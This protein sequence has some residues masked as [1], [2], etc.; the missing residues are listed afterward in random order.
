MKSKN[1][2]VL[3]EYNP[4]LFNLINIDSIEDDDTSYQVIETR[5]GIPTIQVNKEGRSRFV[6]SK[7]D[8]KSEAEKFI[9]Q[10]QENMGDY[11]HVLF[12][13]VGLGYHIEAFTKRNPMFKF[14][15]YEP[16]INI[17][18]LYAEHV[19]IPLYRIKNI[20][21]ET[22][23]EAGRNFLIKLTEEIQERI[24]LII[25]PSY[26]QIF[27]DEFADFMEDFK[28]AVE[29][30]KQS[31]YIDT[32]FSTR[33]TINSLLNFSTTIKT[34]NILN[35]T[36]KELFKQ[37]PLII[38]SA[39]PSLEEEYE[40][41]RYIKQHKLAY[42]FAVGSAN[43]ALI[44]QNIIPDA[45]TTYDPQGHNHN[46]YSSII[47]KGI[48]SIPM[49][50]G[51]SVG[52]ETL[53]LFQGPKLHMF[54]SQDT[55]S[56]YY[57]Q[58]Q[59][60]MNFEFIEDAPTIA[61]VTFQLA[62]KLGCSPVVFVGQNLAYRNNQYYSK[63]VQ[64]KDRGRSFQLQE[65]DRTKTTIVKDVY[66]M[67]IESSPSFINMLENME[68]YIA[69]YKNV[70]VINTTNGG[71][72]IA[73]T[74]F[75]PLKDFTKNRL[76][77][78]VVQENWFK[79][80][81]KEYSENHILKYINKMEQSMENFQKLYKEILVVLSD[82]QNKLVK[83]NGSQL[84]K[85]FQKFDKIMKKIIMNECYITYIYP[86][87]RSH[88]QSLSLK[89]ANIRKQSNDIEKAKVLIESFRPFLE[90]CNETIERI[91]ELILREHYQLY[92][93]INHKCYKYYDV[94]NGCFSFTGHVKKRY[95]NSG[96]YLF[97]QE[98]N[99]DYS[100]IKFR[101]TGKYLRLIGRKVTDNSCIQVLIDGEAVNSSTKN[102][103]EIKASVFEISNLENQE[104][105]VEIRLLE[106]SIFWFLGVEVE[107][108]ERVLHVNEVT[109]IDELEIGKKI[110]CH[111]TATYNR[112]GTFDNLGKET[113]DFIPN[114]SMGN[115]NGDFYFIMVDEDGANK[116]L[117]ADRN[118]Q[119]SVSFKRLKEG[120]DQNVH[121]DNL[122]NTRIRLPQVNRDIDEWILYIQN[123]NLNNTIV[124]NDENVWNHERNVDKSYGLHSFIDQEEGKSA[125]YS[126]YTNNEM[127]IFKENTLFEIDEK[128]IQRL[129]GFRPV[130]IIKKIK[131]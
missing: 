65:T 112:I 130:L 1:L 64:Y 37:K 101:F 26:Q 77:S 3:R 58:N 51:T 30:K 59:N 24:L 119:N 16:K 72:A 35:Q 116:K 34:P 41:L 108:N 62:A 36:Y 5:T 117:I 23:R 102:I 27:K 122:L 75:I 53:N 92:K 11:D 73:G 19:D 128:D 103:S 25:L 8:P 48:E 123:S 109:T 105:Q 96:I 93:N 71:A 29:Y 120:L 74:E 38:V 86:I 55:V 124:A 114:E 44:A 14:S 110:R 126:Y 66:G 115:P 127:N 22:S 129:W 20:F 15:I 107:E 82:I 33:W 94:N 106:K 70:E 131:V 95:R 113:V 88:F 54:T 118:I 60:G 81:Q 18:K 2:S 40:N 89:A 63:E 7:Y 52:F 49:I 47:E 98:T 83:K 69:K 80:T 9:E 45:V 17:F 39:G 56:K 6:H 32:K 57:L 79:N 12:Y 10:F 84:A 13:G 104:H 21:V 61:S 90:R 87:N 91:T 28:M 111:Y 43:K 31:I 50:Y 121:I 68:Y 99:T 46:V 67:D 42:I 85:K 76:H 100:T 4:S 97:K 78:P 125:V